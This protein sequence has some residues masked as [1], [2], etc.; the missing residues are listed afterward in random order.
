[1]TDD[2]SAD[3]AESIRLEQLTESYRFDEELARLLTQ[4][5]YQ[6]DGIQ[7]TAAESRPL[8][9]QRVAP[10]TVG[11]ATVF[12]ADS[13]LVFLCYDDREHT[14]VNPIETT[15]VDALARAVAE[16]TAPRPD[17]GS[18]RP[19]GE[20]PPSAPTATE[21]QPANQPE[22]HS[23]SL[24]MGVVTPHNAQRGALASELPAGV[25]ANTVEKYQGGERDVI[26]VSATVSDPQFARTEEQF[27]LNPRRLLVAISRSRLLTVVVC[28]TALFEVAP[29]DSERLD[30]GPI[31]ARLF[32]QAVGKDLEPAWTGTLGAFVA[33]KTGDHADVP[34][35]VYPSTVGR[36]DRS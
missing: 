35:Q 6:A 3:S 25:T 16:R 21:S 17:G 30:D 10:I 13:S 31:W 14:M 9:A 7:L 33:D 4:F 32:T 26:A 29:Q 23:E 36:G 28:S 27:I 12:G 5:Q 1:M 11:Q 8:P 24:S 15:L 22:T 20:G 18:G 19:L 2:T 34:V